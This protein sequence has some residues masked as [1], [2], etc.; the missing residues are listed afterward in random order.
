MPELMFKGKE[1]VYNHHLAVPFRPIIPVKD[2]SVGIGSLDDNLIIHG[3]N[4][5]GLKALLPAYAG[6]IDCIIIDPPYNIG[7]ENWSYNDN[8][9]SPL[10]REWLL[11]NPINKDDLLRSDK[12]L[13]M[14]Y[15]RLKLLKELLSYDGLIAVTIDDNELKNLLLVMDEIWGPENC[16]ACAVWLSD[17]SGGKQKSALRTGH[18]YVVIYGG[19]SPELAKEEKVEVKLD[20]HDKWG[21]YAKGREL[22]KW[23][24]GSLRKDRETMFY[25]LKAPDG[26]EVWPIRN[27]GQD[28]RWRYGRESRYIKQILA[29]PEE[30]HWELRPFDREVFV[31]GQKVDRTTIKGHKERWVPYEKIRDIK[32]VFGWSSWLDDVAANAD[33]T[34][35]LK[36]IFGEKVFDTPKPVA[37]IEWILGLH[38]NTDC[39]VLDS[40]AG[41]GTTAHAVMSLNNKDGGN[42]RFI[43]IECEEY[44]DRLTA[45]R[46]RR[47][48]HGVSFAGVEKKELFRQRLTLTSLKQ[49]DKLLEKVSAIED[50]EHGFDKIDRKVEN[51]IL[52]VVGK[53][54]VNGHSEGLSGSFTFCELGEPLD[55]NKLLSGET[56]PSFETLGAWL[57]HTATNEPFDPAKMDAAE[58]YLGESA[59]Y[60]VWLIY[61][62]DIK[63]LKSK[64]AALTLTKAEE[65]AKKKADK[66]HLVFAPA[67]FVSQRLLNERGL[68]IDFALLPFSLYKIE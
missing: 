43:L 28:G 16:L 1:F 45:E 61:Q 21:D 63:F 20:H 42:R 25:P 50:S 56:L 8:V 31:N 12:W 35:T 34:Q 9:N 59:T 19:G 24:A 6:K 47:V 26:T 15:P 54:K 27:D 29:D 40:F 41:S 52:T 37:L 11:S 5:H 49:A 39:L 3:D 66:R 14:M 4:L 30:A 48:I 62:P 67:K 36:E 23:G 58:G 53:R 22:L 65:L 60:H 32:K 44:A 18:E 2:K 57:F 10:M 55:L 7:S 68:A 13:C 64:E 38:P 33:G 46:M 51:G 17:P